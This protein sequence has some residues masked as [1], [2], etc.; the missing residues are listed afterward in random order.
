MGKR[1]FGIEVFYGLGV[2]F[3]WGLTFL[4]IKVAVAELKPMTLALSR[5]IIASALLPLIALV[6]KTPLAV[7]PKDLPLLFVS[8]FI[9][10]TL[11]FFFENNG[12]MRLSASESS[13]IIGT[14]PVLTLLVDTVF[15]RLRASK[16]VIIGILLSFGGVAV[17][18]AKSHSAAAS[19]G[20][21]LFMGGAAVA[22]VSYTFLTKPLGLKYPILSV[23]FWQIFFGMLGCVPFALFEGQGFV[24]V[25][26][27]VLLNV[28]FLGVLA[29]AGGYWLW[30]MVL[31]KLGA[32]RSSVFINLI[33]VVSVIA[34][35]IV[36]GERLAPVQLAGGAATVIGVY[37]ATRR[38]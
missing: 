24:R 6:N 35:F 15:Y 23:T 17:M 30:V 32:S 8:G 13:I 1:K 5:F 19:T 33:P 22:W 25:S 10:V 28:V 18:V 36:L 14:I 20:G 21:Y 34:S 16:S 31:D 38:A 29:S 3:I 4:S 11:Y 7:K 12:I 2:A 37:L 27:P 9:G 26:T